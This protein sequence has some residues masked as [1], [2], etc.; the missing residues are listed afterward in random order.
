MSRLEWARHIETQEGSG[1]SQK[2][3]CE[4]NQVNPHNF[5]Y[6]RQRLKKEA[7]KIN[8]AEMNETIEDAECFAFAQVSIQPEIRN[9]ATAVATVMMGSI[10]L[11]ISGVVLTIPENYTEGFLLRLIQTL[12]RL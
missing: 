12:K 9:G 8:Q 4:A 6:W 2:K 10:Q 5:R 1:L 3:W 11:E 7:A